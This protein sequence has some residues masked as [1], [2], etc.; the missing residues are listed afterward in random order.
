MLLLFERTFKAIEREHF[1]VVGR[2]DLA[3]AL[4]QVVVVLDAEFVKDHAHVRRYVNEVR[5][6]EVVFLSIGRVSG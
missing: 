2:H 4:E 3:Y 5:Y 6:F 1:D